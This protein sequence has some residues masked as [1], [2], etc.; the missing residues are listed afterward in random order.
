VIIE[1]RDIAVKSHDHILSKDPRERPLILYT[2]GSGIEGR[3]G[4]AVVDLQNHHAHSQ[5]GDNDTSTVYAAELRGIE[6]A[7][8]SMALGTTRVKNG[9][10]IFVD[11]QAAL[12]A[13]RQPR[14]PSGQIYLEG[15]L[16]LIRRHAANGIQT[17]LRWIPAHQGVA[18]NE[19]VDQHAKEA[20]LEPQGPQ[21]PDNRYIRLAAAAKRRIRRE[22]KA[23]WER[24]WVTEKT[25]RPTKRLIELPTK[26][27]L[28]YWSD[29]R[30]AT[31]SIL[32]QLRTGRIGLGAYL[33]RI[34]RRESAR[35]SCDLGNQTVNHILLECPLLQDERNWMRNALSDC[36]VALRLDELLTRPEARVIVAEFMIRTNLL[37]QFQAVDP[38]ALGMEEGDEGK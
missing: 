1:D 26:K 27:T 34:N 17:E 13:L 12:K 19:L 6:M 10:V 37:E 32:M 38:M 11:S 18:G 9:I 15:C 23:E 24:S 2:D 20:A 30:K 3:I 36:G 16:G 35:C 33:R 28:E 25:S 29:L 14:M 22:A 4:A 31:T 21:K 7:L 5:M 8:G